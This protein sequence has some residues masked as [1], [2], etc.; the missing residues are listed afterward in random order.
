MIGVNELLKD[1]QLYHSDFQMDNF[2]TLRSG[3]TPYGQYK[4][5]LRELDKRKRGLKGL[6]AEKALLQVDIDE[7]DANLEYAKDSFDTR[8]NNIERGK[9]IMRMEDLNRNIQD[10]E[11]EFVRF[12]SQAASLKEQIGELTPE[13]RKQ[14][15][16]DMWAFNLKKLAAM[17]VVT[18]G[19]VQK[20]TLEIIMAAPVEMRMK[21]LEELKPNNR[22]K[23][24][25]WLEQSHEQAFEVKELLEVPVQKLLEGE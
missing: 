18:V 24:V 13:R 3:G 25:E 20:N 19:H 8:R 22:T 14:L 5:A 1:H 12:Y 2:I 9:N 7:L 23:L 10:T 11:R 16:E 4:Q 17:D 6:Y 15:D 21:T